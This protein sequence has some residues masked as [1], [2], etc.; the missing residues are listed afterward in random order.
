M[1][2]KF[3]LMLV[4]ACAAAACTATACGKANRTKMDDY[5]EK[6]YKIFVTYD[7]QPRRVAT[8]CAFHNLTA[9]YEQGRQ[10]IFRTD[11]RAVRKG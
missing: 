3:K 7:G 1:K 8:A 11:F 9:P 5:E 10:V 2:K 4:L 6:G